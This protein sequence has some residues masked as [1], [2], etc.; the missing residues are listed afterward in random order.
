MTTLE[1]IAHVFGPFVI[2]LVM[3]AVVDVINYLK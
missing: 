3:A 2:V 1:M